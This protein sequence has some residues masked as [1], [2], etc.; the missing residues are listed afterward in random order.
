MHD[1]S[2]IISSCV[3]NPSQH[4][5]LLEPLLASAHQSTHNKIKRYKQYIV[6]HLGHEFVL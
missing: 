2:N 4:Q 6:L 5:Q 1:P 3:L